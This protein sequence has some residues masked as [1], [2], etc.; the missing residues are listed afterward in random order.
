[1]EVDI[2]D[3]YF[4]FL[5]L[6]VASLAAG[7]VAAKRGFFRVAS[8][9]PFPN[10]IKATHVAGVFFVYLLFSLIVAVVVR[11]L[12]INYLQARWATIFA[13]LSGVL[14]V[15]AALRL[16]PSRQAVWSRKDN[17]SFQDFLVGM[18]T[19]V[20]AY[21]MSML[22]SS[23]VTTLLEMLGA[24]EPTEQVAVSFF[25]GVVAHTDL[26]IVTILF[27][28]VVGPIVEEILFRGLLLNYLLQ[29]FPFSFANAVVSALFALFHYSAIQSWYNLSVL[30]PLFLLSWFLG[31]LFFRQRALVASIALHGTFNAINAILIMVVE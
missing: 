29:R 8:Y 23:V 20:L 4:A 7:W 24:G 11:N 2:L 10:V 5:G 26:L 3:S 31:F 22:L 16:L 14:V 19:A 30:A 1:M 17:V 9:E 15:L 28:V 21:P 27:V 25:R 13:N 12:S 6:V 18:A